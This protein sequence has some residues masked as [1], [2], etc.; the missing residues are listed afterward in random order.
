M[1]YLCQITD[2]K[3]ATAPVLES[4]SKYKMI[5]TS[6]VRNGNLNIN[7]MDN[8]S[9][10]VYDAWSERIYLKYN[11]VVFSREAPIGEVSIIPNDNNLYFLGQRMVAMRV[12]EKLSP[13]FLVSTFMASKF[14]KE[15]SIRNAESTTVANFGITSLNKYEISLPTYEEQTKIGNFFKQLDETITLQERKN[16]MLDKYLIILSLS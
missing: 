5:R 6:T 1:E 7:Q 13:R 14:K 12:N 10:E 15:I 16:Y 3:H 2:A 4:E 8:V 11:D 9:K